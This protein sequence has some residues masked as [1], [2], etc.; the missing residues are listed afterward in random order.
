MRIL[1]VTDAWTPQVNGVVRTLQSLRAELAHMGHHV[2]ML[3]PDLFASLPCP[4]YPEIRLALAFG[5]AVDA[6]ISGAAPDAI[7]IATEGP[8]GLAARNWCLRHGYPFTSAYHTQFPEYVAKRTRMPSNWFWRYIRWFHAPAASVLVS[9]PTVARQL[10]AN[11]IVRTRHWGR[12]VDT[13]RFRPDIPPLPA[14]ARL[15]RPIQLYVGRLAIEKNVAAFLDT[16]HPGSKVVVGEGP[17]SNSLKQ[18]YP[19]ASF[20]GALH[21]DS[22]ASAYA[23]ADVLVFP[24]RTDTFG[25][26]MIEALSCGVPVAAFPVPGPSDILRD[27]VGAMDACLARAIARALK[28]DRSA[29]AEYAG[30]FS[31]AA[32]ARQFLDALAP[33]E[34]KQ[35]A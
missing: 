20:T 2:V 35:A 11:G 33:I 29:C 30:S 17:A 22:L 14:F 32:S 5:R 26:V 18:R 9:T 4:T 27:D 21:G 7:H 12:G 16:G 31:W 13:A 3:S 24:S 25:L 10:T 23:A 15:T 19:H 1:I 34:R 6:R 8:L 28:L